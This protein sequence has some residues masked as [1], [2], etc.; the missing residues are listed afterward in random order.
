MQ[1]RKKPV[2]IEAWPWHPGKQGGAKLPD[3]LQTAFDEEVIVHGT[4]DTLLIETLEGVMTVS[5]DDWI[6]QG[7]Q[8]ELYPCKPDIFLD[9]YEPT[10]GID[11]VTPE[12]DP[13]EDTAPGDIKEALMVEGHTG[14]LYWWP[15]HEDD[16]LGAVIDDLQEPCDIDGDNDWVVV[17]ATNQREAFTKIAEY[18]NNQDNFPSEFQD[19]IDQANDEHVGAVSPDALLQLARG[20]WV[21]NSQHLIHEVTHDQDNGLDA[22]IAA[23][24]KEYPT[25]TEIE[26]YLGDTFDYWYKLANNRGDITL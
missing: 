4:N 5:P 22:V 23:L 6:I 21:R 8:G 1:F 20:N 24:P 16:D 3:W 25:D 9:T 19:A 26:Q 13:D 15:V 7:V 11:M 14:S 10:M 17:T 12:D 2:T 18:Y